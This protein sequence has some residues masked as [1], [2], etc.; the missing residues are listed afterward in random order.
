MSLLPKRGLFYVFELPGEWNLSGGF[1]Q[2]IK[3]QGENV[4]RGL[5][6]LPSSLPFVNATLIEPIACCLQAIHRA[7][8]SVG[9]TVVVVGAGFNGLILTFLSKILVLKKQ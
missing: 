7:G 8:V 5:L 1:S 9:D 6:T 3:V 2:F 4:R